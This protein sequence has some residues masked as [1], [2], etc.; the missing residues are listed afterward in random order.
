MR[1][2][3]RKQTRLGEF[4]FT[5]TRPS[6]DWTNPLE[7]HLQSVEHLLSPLLLV[8]HGSVARGFSSLLCLNMSRL[9]VRAPPPTTQ[10]SPR[11]VCF[12]FTLVWVA[13]SRVAKL[14]SQTTLAMLR[15][16]PDPVSLFQ[17][18]GNIEWKWGQGES[19]RE[20]ECHCWKVSAWI[21]IRTFYYM[22]TYI[23]PGHLHYQIPDLTV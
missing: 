11:S 12:P 3:F 18:S 16:T 17:M 1:D 21:C 22:C 4:L 2:M 13:C 8:C 9:C 5:Q 20:I 15:V 7:L 10:P 14:K 6:N 19:R 23:H